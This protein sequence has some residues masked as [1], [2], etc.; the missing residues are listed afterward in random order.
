MQVNLDMQMYNS[1]IS[2]LMEYL[3]TIVF[4]IKLLTAK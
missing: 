2:S 1:L 4:L 3:Q